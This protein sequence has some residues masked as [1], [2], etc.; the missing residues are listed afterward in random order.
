MLFPS[1]DPSFDWRSFLVGDCAGRFFAALLLVEA[2]GEAVL[3]WRACSSAIL[4]SIDSLI[5][6]FRGQ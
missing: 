2:L 5:L 1:P 6:L 4:L 3:R